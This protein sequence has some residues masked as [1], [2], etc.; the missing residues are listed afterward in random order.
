MRTIE[1]INEININKTNKVLFILPHPDDET[2]FAAG[3]IQKLIKAHVQCSLITVTTGENSTLRNGLSLDMS[4]K[5]IRNSELKNACKILGL[6]DITVYD[7][8]DGRV[9]ENKEEIMEYVSVYI[10]EKKPNVVITLEPW[11]I[12]GHP[13]HISLTEIVTKLCALEFKDTQLI[14]LTV[15]QR[16][17][18]SV[19]SF[20]M[21]KNPINIK[22]IPPTIILKL[23]PLEIYNKVRALQAH[24]TQFKTSLDFWKKWWER[25]L[26]QNE[27]LYIIKK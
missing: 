12:Y 10:K 13:D 4:L 27:F 8:I 15:D 24:K 16:Y 7:F 21:A 20:K 11:G 26:L 25:G 5:F 18:P 22:P 19:S 23:S 3:L 9:E 2:V 14:Y 17:R 6:K 1:N